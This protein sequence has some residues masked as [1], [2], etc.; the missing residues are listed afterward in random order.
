MMDLEVLQER[1]RSYCLN[2][3]VNYLLESL[4]VLWLGRG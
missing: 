1:S 4:S 2:P 3:G